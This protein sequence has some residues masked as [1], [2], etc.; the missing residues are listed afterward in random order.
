MCAGL[1]KRKR[2][3]NSQHPTTR[4]FPRVTGLRAAYGQSFVLERASLSVCAPSGVCR[5]RRLRSACVRAGGTWFVAPFRRAVP[6]PCP[7]IHV[8]LYCV[9]NDAKKP[10]IPRVR[11][12]THSRD[13]GDRAHATAN[14]PDHRDYPIFQPRFTIIVHT[15]THIVYDDA[16]RDVNIYIYINI[17]RGPCDVYTFGR[18]K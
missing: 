16:Q 5:V 10:I 1:V 2:S 13:F 9:T 7:R 11:A 3:D 15:H 17:K 12:Y 4:S 18:E 6:R 14:S 8:Y